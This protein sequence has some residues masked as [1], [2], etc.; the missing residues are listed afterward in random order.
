MR[1]LKVTVAQYPIHW[2]NI[3]KNIKFFSDKLDSLKVKT[4]LIIFPEMFTTGFTMNVKECSEDM[5]GKAVQ[6]VKKYSKKL[7]A[8]VCGSVIIKSGNK[9]FNRLIVGLPD[10][11]IKFY[12]KRHLFRMA[13]EHSVYSSGSKRLILKIKDWRIAFF[14]CYDL[15]FPV[16]SRNRNSYDAAVYSANW[17]KERLYYW[18]NLLL[19]RAIENQSYI[20]GANRTGSDKN[21]FKF[22]GNSAVINP[23]G[24]YVLDAKSK[25]GLFTAELDMD[26]LVKFK[27]KFPAY[28]DADRFKIIL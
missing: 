2:E 11:K 13:K 10:G 28:K 26:S 18:K 20:I 16:W 22:T 25:S 8:A 9:Y 3:D 4:D 1:N 15:R 5:N 7:N 14:V 24:K 19:A 21:G 27:E 23:M 12:D 17:P 6:F